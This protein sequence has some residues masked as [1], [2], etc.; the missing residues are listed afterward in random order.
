MYMMSDGGEGAVKIVPV[1]MDDEMVRL[2]DVL[3]EGETRSA[4]VRK[5][6]RA[7][8]EDRQRQL[9][10]L[11]REGDARAARQLQALLALRNVYA[12]LDS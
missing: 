9:E 12:P 2:L 1:K 6:I 3:A 8:G 4:E 11:Q 10:V 5:A 7:A